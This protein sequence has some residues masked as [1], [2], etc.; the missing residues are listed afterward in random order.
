[1]LGHV[2]RKEILS[3]IVSPAF[4]A[5]FVLCAGLIL[6]SFYTGLRNYSD[7]VAEVQMTESLNR[8]ALAET[9]SYRDVGGKGIQAT[10]P[11]RPMGILV[12]GLENSLGRHTTITMHSNPSMS[13]SK[14]EGNPIFALF[15]NLDLMFIVKTVLSLLAILFT[16]D[17]IS[18]DKEDGTLRLTLSHA[19]P[20]DTLILGK[21]IGGLLCLMIPLSVPV[22]FG[23]AMLTLYPDVSLAGTDWLRFLCILA[24][25]AMY[26][27]LF[28]TLGLFV[29]SRTYRS[30]VSFLAL[31]FVWVVCTL[32]IPKGSVIV[33]G[34]F[35][36]VPSIQE[37]RMRVRQA[38]YNLHME[39]R[40]DNRKYREEN[41]RPKRP[42]MAPNASKADVARAKA[43]YKASTDEW[44]KAYREKM[45]ASIAEV[46]DLAMAQRERMDKEYANRQESL[47]GLAVQIS[48][49]SPASAMTYAAM[50]LA[51]TG[52][53]GQ[54]HFLKIVRAYREQ[55]VTYVQGKGVPRGGIMIGSPNRNRE[56][57]K[58]VD[59]SDMPVFQYQEEPLADA[60]G[61]TAL[62]VLL[63]GILTV[64]LFVGAYFSFL[65]YD[66]R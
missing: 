34:Q 64:G 27:A 58:P 20:R 24:V 45:M 51:G 8:E 38:T 12:S 19:V 46:Q 13:G 30:S 42:E 53:E 21:M 10:K 31:L 39:H 54:N 62:D 49:I 43:A 11:A 32:I 41:P 35:V 7:Q 15:G 5:T 18:G 28:F 3:N 63:M 17:A 33:A 40:F 22:L 66:P 1:M 50:N 29:S 26:M 55:F 23:V 9:T 47:A 37:H 14:V 57:P 16:Y 6:L 4:I 25:F 59:V 36:Q 48:R 2:V 65:R 56:E 44:M 52:M 60:V 61:R